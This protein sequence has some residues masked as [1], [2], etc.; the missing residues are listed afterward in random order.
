MKDIL[1]MKC[2]HVKLAKKRH[3]ERQARLQKIELERQ[4]GL[5]LKVK[6]RRYANT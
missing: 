4:R 2:V 1:E 6:E 5:E 3:D